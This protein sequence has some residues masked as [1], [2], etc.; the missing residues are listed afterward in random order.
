MRQTAVAQTGMMRTTVEVP[1]FPLEHRCKVC[2]LAHT[3]PEVFDELTRRLLN[4][5]KRSTILTWLKRQGITL[6]ERGL[7]RH[8]QRHML[9]YYKEALEV[10]RRLRAEMAT[11]GT[12]GSATIASA[13]A[14]SLAMRALTAATL[15]DFEALAKE[16]DPKLIRELSGLARTIAQIDALAADA[17][18][19]EKLVQLRAIEVDLKG[20]RLDEAAARWI[21][22]RLQERPAVARQVLDLL[23]LPTPQPEMK[24]LPQPNASKTRKR[25]QRTRGKSTRRKR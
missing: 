6:T 3:H 18:L 25:S 21:L 15:I 7:S 22:M 10:E 14:R 9:P 4:A 2:L 13:L 24:A 5:Q 11:I 19:K 20:N 23:G 17:R 8:Y 16:A 12:E 1:L